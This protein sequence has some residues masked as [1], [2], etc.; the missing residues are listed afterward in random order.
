MQLNFA[1][2][3]IDLRDAYKKLSLAGATPLIVVEEQGVVDLDAVRQAVLPLIF[4]THPAIVCLS[5]G[6][7]KHFTSGSRDGLISPLHFEHRAPSFF[8]TISCH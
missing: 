3:I 7:L 6:S 5:A 4:A 2:K 1:V 8:A